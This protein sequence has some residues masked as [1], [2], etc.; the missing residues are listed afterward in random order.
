ML[1][2]AINELEKIAR[3]FYAVTHI[4]I[5]LYDDE[6]R[7]LYSYP[8]N[9]CELCSAVRTNPTLVDKCFECDNIGFDMCDRTGKPYIYR[10][11][12]NLSEA[13]APIIENGVTIGYMMLG[14]VLID[15]DIEALENQINEICRKYDFKF[16]ELSKKM[17]K[18]MVMGQSDIVSA[19]SIMSMCSCYLYVNKIIRN[20]SDILAYQL[21]DYIDNHFCEPLTIAQICRKFYISRSKLYTVSVNVFGMGVTDY[22]KIKR[23]EVAKKLLSH[24]E[25]SIYQISEE[26]GFSDHNY[27]IRFFKKNVGVT[28]NKYRK[29]HTL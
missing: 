21:K 25:K 14:Q 13:I 17:R 4:K 8:S 29:A 2:V 22:I 18:L 27:F 10:C 7:V 3:D 5:V 11:H 28:P 19:V 16:N 15:S 20:K 12:M 26:V 6:R 1:D 24:S 9:M 23:I